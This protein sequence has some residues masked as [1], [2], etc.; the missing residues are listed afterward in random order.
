MILSLASCMLHVC[1]CNNYN[2]LM[3]STNGGL[4]CTTMWIERKTLWVSNLGHLHLLHRLHLVKHYEKLWRD[5]G[6]WDVW[7]VNMPIRKSLS[8]LSTSLLG[9]IKCMFHGIITQALASSAAAAGIYWLPE[10][11]N[12]CPN[13]SNLRLLDKGATNI[14]A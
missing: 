8:T 10:Y 5:K 9:H 1:L 3:L 11:V 12:F 4:M 6:I 2:V 7:D 13:L 14:H